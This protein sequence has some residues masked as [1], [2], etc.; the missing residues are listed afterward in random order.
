[1]DVEELARFF[2]AL[3]SKS[4]LE[5]VLEL[6]EDSKCHT[7]LSSCIGKDVSTVWRHVKVLEDA[8]IVRSLK[9]GKTVVVEVV[10]PASTRALLDLAQKII[11]GTGKR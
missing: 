4:R 6:L 1:M 7:D 2:S 8:G 5:I 10:D 11:S 3:G 9:L